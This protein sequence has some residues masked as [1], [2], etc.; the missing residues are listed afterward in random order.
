MKLLIV[1]DQIHAAQTLRRG[2]A[3]HGFLADLAQDGEE[4]LHMALTGTYACLILDVMLPKKDG[5]TLLGELRAAGLLTPVLFL[6]AKD[7]VADRVRGLESGG[8]DYLVKPFAFSELVARLRNILR[9][10][11]EVRPRIHIVGDLTLDPVRRL[12]QRADQRLDLSVQE[13]AL[14]ELLVRNAGQP[15]TRTRI[16]EEVWDIAFE[17]DSNVVDVAMRRLRRKVDDPFEIKLIC[18]LRGVGYVLDAQ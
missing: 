9:Q 11:T 8:N 2:L 6:T 5:F 12:V 17:G 7:A 18:T 14:L 16:L 1:E 4:G 3:E 13:Y 15:V 10:D